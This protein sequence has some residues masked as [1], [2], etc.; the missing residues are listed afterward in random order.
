MM[1]YIA[2]HEET[3]AASFKTL[4][5]I[6]PIGHLL[7][8]RHVEYHYEKDPDLILTQLHWIRVGKEG[9]SGTNT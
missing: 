1:Q 5:I 7:W 3:T 4:Q 8:A 6:Q 2:V 9:N